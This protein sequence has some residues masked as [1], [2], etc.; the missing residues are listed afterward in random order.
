M[1]PPPSRNSVRR[2]VCYVTDL[3]TVA[4]GDTRSLLARIRWAV[5]AGVDWVQIREK[6]LPTKDLLSFVSQA[7]DL[8]KPRVHA[9]ILVNDRLEVAVTARAGGIHL[10]RES[11]PAPEVVAWCRNRMTPAEFLVGV[12][13][14]G[15]REARQAEAAGA[16]YI[17][18]GPI[19]DTPAKRRFGPPQG[20]AQLETIC[21][22][23]E[24]P[25]IAIGGVNEDNGGECFRAGAAGIAA[26]RL[27]QEARDFRMLQ[28]AV[29]HLHS[30]A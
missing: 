19:F 6:N 22:T 15:S 2:V 21:S 24:I 16:N 18:F 12:S 9:R 14:H 27:F 1:E 17:I 11:M 25:V 28:D 30:A 29:G 13:C 5:E 20:L 26:I 3:T 7:V 23:V 4:G 10:G 8:A